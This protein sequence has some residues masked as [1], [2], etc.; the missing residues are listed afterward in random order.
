MILFEKDFDTEKKCIFLKNKK[1]Y[2]GCRIYNN[3]KDAI[4]EMLDY[5]D[6]MELFANDIFKIVKLWNKESKEFTEEEWLNLDN[7]NEDYKVQYLEF[8]E[9]KSEEFCL[10]IVKE[11]KGFPLYFIKNQTE[12]MCLEAVKQNGLSLQYVNIK[13]TKE[14]ILEALK[15]NG[16]ALQYV[17]NPT[18]EMILEALKNNYYAIKWVK[19]QTEEII[20]EAVKHKDLIIKNDFDIVKYI[21]DDYKMFCLEKLLKND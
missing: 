21:N 14:M 7:V 6:N 19:E 18:K 15:N 13:K 16:F 20:L 10:K 3:I 11:Y 2:I 17:K 8:I 12:K 9:N 5:Y 4:E 1:L